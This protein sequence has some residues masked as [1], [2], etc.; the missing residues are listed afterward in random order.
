M[1]QGSCAACI[2]LVEVAKHETIHYNE[3]FVIRCKNV[4]YR[5]SIFVLS[6][7]MLSNNPERDAMK[8]KSLGHHREPCIGF[9]V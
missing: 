2:A 4:M 1:T 7:V 3:F 8:H 5:N 6:C 9:A